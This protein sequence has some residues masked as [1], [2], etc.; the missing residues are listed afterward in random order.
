MIDVGV[1]VDCADGG[2]LPDCVGAGR[3]GVGDA[4]AGFARLPAVLRFLCAV[5]GFVRWR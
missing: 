4:C 3:F 1:G 2:L 5:Q